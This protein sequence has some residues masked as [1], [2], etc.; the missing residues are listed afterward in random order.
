MVVLVRV[1]S[2]DL[3]DLFEIMFKMILNYV[4]TFGSSHIDIVT[5]WNHIIVYKLLIFSR[6]T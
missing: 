6:N 4:N 3:I 2:V 5:T 1:L